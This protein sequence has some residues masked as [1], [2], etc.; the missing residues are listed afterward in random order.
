MTWTNECSCRRSDRR[1]VRWTIADVVDPV[2]PECK[3]I[4][5][6]VM[7]SWVCQDWIDVI[8]DNKF[9]KQA[10]ENGSDGDWPKVV[11]LGWLFDFGHWSDGTGFP[12]DGNY[13]GCERQIEQVC[14]GRTDRW[15]RNAYEPVRHSIST[16]GCCCQSIQHFKNLKFFY[17]RN[18]LADTCLFFRLRACH[19]S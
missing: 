10:Q 3:L 15:S 19:P 13:G 4:E 12:L 7:C 6:K 11:A 9:F 2:G 16:R 18:P 5:E 17:T 8:A 1:W 14:D